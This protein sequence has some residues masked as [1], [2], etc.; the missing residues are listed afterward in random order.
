MLQF[1]ILHVTVPEGKQTNEGIKAHTQLRAFSGSA[2]SS[3]DLLQYSI[4]FKIL[5][6]PQ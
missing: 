1:C 4:T 6:L 5:L 3:H 2:P